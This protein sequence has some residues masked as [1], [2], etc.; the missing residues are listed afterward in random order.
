MELFEQ[1]RLGYA[2]GE[3][4][5]GMARK[6]GVHRRMVR[7]AIQTAIPPGRKLTPR[8][9]R[10]LDPVRPFIDGILEA[11]KQAPRKQRHTAHRIWIR[12]REQFLNTTSRNR[13]C[14]GTCANANANADSR[15][16]RFSFRNVMRRA[17]KRKPIGTKP[18]SGS[19]IA[20]ESCTSFRCAAWPRATPFTAP[21]RT[22]RNRRCSTHTRKRSPISAVCS[23]RCATILLRGTRS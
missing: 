7:Q 9:A 21:I 1:I 16:P 10:K 5:L 11:D 2:A 8:Q 3:T 4:I 17:R 18:R 22:P 6:H 19:A 13:R 20:N 14:A 23:A 12:V 15:L